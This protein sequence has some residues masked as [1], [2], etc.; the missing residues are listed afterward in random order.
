MGPNVCIQVNACSHVLSPEGEDV[1]FLCVL[2]LS[3]KK[4]TR[5]ES[6]EVLLTLLLTHSLVDTLEG[7]DGHTVRAG[8]HHWDINCDELTLIAN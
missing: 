6:F 4:G 7:R 5:S 1:V 2:F 3:D 8:S